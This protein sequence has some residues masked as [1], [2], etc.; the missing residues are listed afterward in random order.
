MENLYHA[1]IHNKTTEVSEIIY[2]N[3]SKCI[4]VLIGLYYKF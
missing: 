3:S 4:D 2:L 1:K